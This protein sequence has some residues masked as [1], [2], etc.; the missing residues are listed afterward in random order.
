MKPSWR[1]ATLA[2]MS[3]KLEVQTAPQAP[4][5][6]TCSAPVAKPLTSTRLTSRAAPS[7]SA[8]CGPVAAA[9]VLCA[10][11]CV[12]W[13]T[14]TSGTYQNIEGLRVPSTWNVRSSC[15]R[16]KRELP[17]SYECMVDQVVQKDRKQDD[18]GHAYEGIHANSMLQVWP[19]RSG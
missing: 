12:H 16:K 11:V 4:S 17:T 7:S 6:N 13:W 14:Q 5:Q 1:Q 18:T 3:S 8:P 19:T 10:C 9:C 2:S 15:L